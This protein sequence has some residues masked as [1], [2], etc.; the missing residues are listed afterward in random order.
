[1]ETVPLTCEHCG[2]ELAV[3]LADL[4]AQVHCPHCQQVLQAP[5]AGPAQSA[6]PPDTVFS[7]PSA[8]EIESIFTPAEET[9][10]TLFGEPAGPKVELPPAERENAAASGSPL[11]EEAFPP[12]APESPLPTPTPEPL[13]APLK[14]P[15]QSQLGVLLLIFLIPYAII[16]TGAFLYMLYAYRNL[17]AADPMERMPDPDAKNGAKRVWLISPDHP[18]SDKLKTAL[19]QTIRVGDLEVKPLQVKL[20]AGGDLELRLE[21]KNVSQEALFNPFPIAF[22][23]PPGRKPYTYLQAGDRTIVGGDPEWFRG[24]PGHEKQLSNGDL[25]PGEELIATLTTNGDK[26]TRAVVQRVV[27]TSG[28]LLWRLHVRRGLVEVH[29]RPVSAT[30]VIGVRFRAQD[31]A[32][33]RE[34]AAFPRRGLLSPFDGCL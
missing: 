24:P 31:I 11:N 10:D 8:Q 19:G 26:T 3:A 1:M 22:I 14:R 20:T 27:H 34:A 16:I 23:H 4:G 28:P 5:A 29:G 32:Q 17:S 18:L 15:R 6:S 9:S 33:P 30:A 21:M 2:K 12:A 13:L 7:R 25:R